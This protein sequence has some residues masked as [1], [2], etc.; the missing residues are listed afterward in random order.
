MEE[1][2]VGRELAR[3]KKQRESKGHSERKNRDRH[4]RDSTGQGDRE[5]DE[6]A[7]WQLGRVPHRSQSPLGLPGGG[8]SSLSSLV[9]FLFGRQD[10]ATEPRLTSDPRVSCL[11]FSGAAMAGV[12]H[13]TWFE[14]PGSALRGLQS[15]ADPFLWWPVK[16][17][18][19]PK[20]AEGKL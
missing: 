15:Q 9:L 5:T 4:E 2:G 16:R 10:L 13:H 6:K 18:I 7:W 8:S 1:T 20:K 19:A 12:S 11:C 14:C 17:S 3:G